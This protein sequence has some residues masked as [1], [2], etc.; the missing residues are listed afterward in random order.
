MENS[1]GAG[2]NGGL[3]EAML[4]CMQQHEIKI[5]GCQGGCTPVEAEKKEVAAF[6]GHIV[7]DGRRALCGGNVE[8][9]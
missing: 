9:S 3:V 2:L 7:W 4:G 5:L 8:Q 6:M 1:A